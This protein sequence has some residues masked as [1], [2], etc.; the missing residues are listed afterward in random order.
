MSDKKQKDKEPS[1]AESF[2]NSY[3]NA[4]KQY[5]HQLAPKENDSLLVK[6]LKRLSQGL[7]ILISILLSPIIIFIIFFI[8]VVAI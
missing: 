8:V 3:V 2:W 6:G 5:N 7:V 1:L 4:M